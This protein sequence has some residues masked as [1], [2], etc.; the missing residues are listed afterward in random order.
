VRTL[1]D[2]YRFEPVPAE[3]TEEQAAHVIGTQ[4]NAWTEVMDSPRVVDYMV[5]PRL[6]AVAE[7]AW[8]RLPAPAERD[9]PDFER[10]MRAHYARLDALGVEYRPPAG[11]LPWQRRPGVVGRPIDGRPPIV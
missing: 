6:A 10:R 8:S 1:E 3:L 4:A 11:P 2:V 9:W 7:V 5:F